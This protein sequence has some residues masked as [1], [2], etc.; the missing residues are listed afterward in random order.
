MLRP[1]VYIV[2]TLISFFL[3]LF[4]YTKL[5]GPIPFTVTSNMSNSF[6]V[7][8]TG[9]VEVKPNSANVSVGVQ[10]QGA[11]AKAVQ[12]QM[13]ASINKVTA[14]IKAV[15]IDEKDIQTQNYS[16]N[17]QYDYSAG[18][19][20]TGYMAST[21]LTINIRDVNKANS[22]LDAATAAGAN[23]VGGINFDVSDKTQFE[24]EARQKAVADAKKKAQ[25]A[26]SVA[27]FRL[28]R[29][30]SY[31]ENPDNEPRPILYAADAAK[32]SAAPT[33]V[34]PGTNTVSVNVSIG[35]EI[36]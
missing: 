4:V 1:I 33:Q 27:G 30:V 17:P 21:N 10:S 16:V 20:I 15:G 25:Q 6:T 11:T 3:L 29:I 23:Q 24:N 26:A 5:A 7:D 2:T 28:G 34:Q 22:V 14:A 19:K 35:Y 18:Q 31:S 9:E 32:N 8:G 12:D 36:Y 13:N